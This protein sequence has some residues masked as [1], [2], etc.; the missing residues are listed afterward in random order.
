MKDQ[1]EKPAMVLLTRNATIGETQQ[2]DPKSMLMCVYRM[3]TNHTI[4]THHT[5][6][7]THIHT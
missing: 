1:H 5:H 7:H 4:I 6:T 2:V 3:Y